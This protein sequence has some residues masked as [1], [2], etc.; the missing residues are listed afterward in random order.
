MKVST[1]LTFLVV[2]LAYQLSG[3]I[4][5][6]TFSIL[7]KVKPAF[8]Q[9]CFAN[10][11]NVPVLEKAIKN[12][13]P[14]E[15]IRKFPNGYRVKNQ[16]NDISLIYEVRYANPLP[17]EIAAA[18][19]KATGLVEYAEPK[20]Q[21]NTFYIPNDS[22][23]GKQ[24]ALGL[25]QAPEGWDIEQGDSSVVIGIV[26]TG[27]DWDHPDLIGNVAYNWADPVDGQ[28]NDDDGYTDN[29][30]GWDLYYND[31]DPV[32]VGFHHGTWIAGLASAATD[33]GAGIAGV[34]FRCRFLPIRV[35]RDNSGLTTM[36]YEGIVYAAD[37]GCQI[38]NCSWGGPGIGKF[39]QDVINYATYERGALI[40]AAAGNEGSD[41]VNFPA[42]YEGVI[43]V[44]STDQADKKSTSSNWGISIDLCAPGQALHTTNAG[45][46]YTGYGDNSFSGTSLSA[47][48]VSG[49]AGL[50]RAHFPDWLP[51]QIGEQIR[52]TADI[53]EEIPANTPYAGLLGGGRLNVYRALTETGH[54]SVRLKNRSFSGTNIPYFNPG[55]T[56]NILGDIINYL[57]PVSGMKATI[58]SASPDVEI[59]NAELAIGSLGTLDTVHLTENKWQFRISPEAPSKSTIRFR[60]SYAGDDYSDQEW[61]EIEISSGFRNV[62]I[63]RLKIS[64]GSA[65]RVGFNRDFYKDGIGM[66]F[67][68]RQL[69]YFSGMGLL[70]GTGSS[71]VSDAF[72][73]NF[74]TSE[75]FNAS[76]FIEHDNE[77]SVSDLDL[78]TRFDDKSFA[79]GLQL[80]VTLKT[81][82]WTDEGYDNFHILEYIIRNDGSI[83]ISSLYAGLGTTWYVDNNFNKSSADPGVSMGYVYSTL[84]DP[85][86]AGISILN[87]NAGFH[88]YAIDYEGDGS[89]GGLNV[90]DANGFSTAEKYKALSSDR[91]EGGVLNPNG[92]GVITVTSSG[93]YAI[94]AGDSIVVAFAVL[95]GNDLEE[96]QQT[97]SYAKERYDGLF[98]DTDEPIA[99][100]T[101]FQLSPNPGKSFQ[102]LINAT[103]SGKHV[104]TINDN[105][106]LLIKRESLNLEEGR[107]IWEGPDLKYLP[108]GIYFISLRKPDGSSVTK[109]WIRQE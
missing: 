84:S 30:R 102:V 75:D 94:P 15:I 40:I 71:R 13:A 29:Y 101:S 100:K 97:A 26:D 62:E 3:Q 81:H 39:G 57:A 72:Y 92:N 14:V 45:G 108:A 43:S 63:N 12:L 70:L 28:D 56:V 86:Y 51:E 89:F 65:G 16:A 24:Y 17:P 4:E 79:T 6:P 87:E 50:L 105:S 77:G 2:L 106:G 53:I 61:F 7:F 54:P 99:S 8:R 21:L 60:I 85:L 23:I 48:L 34:G 76:Q 52:V 27:V 20:P 96:L 82:T 22:E 95:A 10:R 88:H 93:P 69:I 38:I 18:A 73:N 90:L 80:N 9:D 49:C 41:Q 25:I 104:I 33:N 83:D 42:G 78:I 35:T 107:S 47:S 1:V 103:V 5:N 36:G 19:I 66:S 98:V 74:N 91:Y 67:E 64:F 109:K 37:H 59:L 44:A 55:D 31:N 68:D 32:S 11:I 58:Y 46:D